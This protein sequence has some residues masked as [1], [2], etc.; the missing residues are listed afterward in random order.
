MKKI[1]HILFFSFIFFISCKEGKKQANILPPVQSFKPPVKVI[2]KNENPKIAGNPEIIKIVSKPGNTYIIKTGNAK[3]APLQLVPPIVK[4]ADFYSNMQSYNTDQGLAL[5]AVISSF[6]DRAG[7][8]WFGTQG[9]GVSKYDGKLFTNYTVSQG[10]ASNYVTGIAEDKAGNIW[11]TTSAGISKYDG[12]LFTNYTNILGL[13]IGEVDAIIKDK[14]DN[15]WF[16]TFNKGIFMFDGKVFKN[17]NST[18]GLI[19]NSVRCI[20][21]DRKGDLWF[22]T[23]AG[24]SR[25]DGDSFKNYAVGND[26]IKT[27]VYCMKEDKNGGYWFGTNRGLMMFDGKSFI[28]N[29]EKLG[30]VVECIFEDKPGNLWFSTEGGGIYKYDCKSFTNY[31]TAQGLVDNS[32]MNIIEDK[33]GNLWFGSNTGGGICRYDGAAFTSFKTSQG[34]SNDIVMC[35]LNNKSGNYWFGTFSEGVNYYDTKKFIHYTSHQGLSD[36]DIRCILEDKNGNTWFGSANGVSKFDGKLFANYYT[37]QGLI[38]NWIQ[39]IIEDK[40]GNIWFG[41]GG[42]GA[43][44]FDGNFFTNYT[45]SQGLISNSIKTIIKDKAGNLW[46][47]TQEGVS[48]Y[49]GKSF[50]NFTTEQGLINNEVNCIAE[51]ATGN[52]WFGT[53]VGISKYDGKSFT[54][55]T[56]NQGLVND[57]VSSIV[58]DKNRNLIIGTNDGISVLKF[59]GDNYL[60][61]TYNQKTGYQIKD[62]NGGSGNGAMLCDSNGV[63]WAGTGDKLVR[64]NYNAIHKNTE[65]PNVVL[66]SLKVNNESISWYDLLDFS[67]GRDKDE[68]KDSNTVASNI[69]EEISVFGKTLETAERDSLNKLFGDIRFDSIAKF[70]PVPYNLVLPY[71]H[72]NLTIEF[73]AIEPARPYLV[74]YQY[75]LEGYDNEWSPITNKTNAS[76][77]NIHEGTYVFKLKAQSPDG[78]WSTPIAYTFKVL[79]PWYRTWWM[80]LTYGIIILL[81]GWL[82][83]RWRTAEL[84]KEKEILETKV[85][86]RTLQLSE[87]NKELSEQKNEIETQKIQIEISHKKVS[88]SINYAQ[89][90]QYSI[91]PSEEEIRNYVPDY[92][93][94]FQPK[95]I[96]SGDF[97]WFYHHNGFSY[98]AVAD[99]TGHGVPGAL[100]SMTIHSLLNEVMMEEKLIVPGEILSRLHSSVYKTL[101]QQKG[102][103]YSQDGC[104]ISLS[105]I[106]H[107]NKLLHFSGAR[108]HA[109]LTNGTNITVIKATSKS[110]G[111]LSMLGEPEPERKFK[112]ETIELKEDVLLIMSTDGIFDQLNNQD[113]SFGNTRFKEM[114]NTIYYQ[115]ITKGNEIVASSINNWKKDLYPQD[116]MLVMGFKLNLQ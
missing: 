113:E 91:L 69:V 29:Q 8:L 102:D 37:S 16:G 106:D 25:Y 34:L 85:K 59:K 42:E 93:V 64:F 68:V 108:N 111:G 13:S 2:V 43:S 112:S 96:I 89:K 33:S 1:S 52:I 67:V 31:T 10:M 45:T 35:M 114:I 20:M 22:G 40:A 101:Q 78:V 6:C 105:I 28:K 73:A 44:K 77:G 82:F 61:E 3:N 15:L 92:F 81:G 84:R 50:T 17:Y 107:A 115:P 9:G 51:D 49:D 70:Y 65:P 57:Y 46:F 103:E 5:S 36:N 83:F 18:Q 58:E 24:I 27:T 116:D 90:I 4:P 97:Y 95:D 60:F 30:Y 14:K 79:P 75:I 74:N 72:N 7:N 87:A 32:V 109:Y 100:M 26:S 21:E 76:F 99:C 71:N 55:F 23:S 94:Y 88:D 80:Y 66:Q 39:S 54:Q 11:F 98:A 63:I 47:G 110:I 56:T 48:K 53:P 86:E 41:T 62:I 19:T 38:N 12:K 104:D